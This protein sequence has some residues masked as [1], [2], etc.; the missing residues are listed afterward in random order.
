MPE[1]GPQ[2]FGEEPRK[3][4]PG[5]AQQRVASWFLD[6]WRTFGVKF[7]ETHQQAAAVL[8]GPFLKRWPWLAKWKAPKGD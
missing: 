8:A 3:E 1:V 5:E 4:S 7:T 2:T 6:I